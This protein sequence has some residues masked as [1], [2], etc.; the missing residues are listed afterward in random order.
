MSEINDIKITIHTGK[1]DID[2]TL[3]ASKAPLT[4][5]NFLNLASK[6][7]Y[8][9]VAFHRIIENF[10]VQGGDPDGTGRGGPGY[11]FADEFHP[12]LRHDRPGILSMANAG[13]G[14]NGS[15]FFIT[16]TPTPF[17]DNRHSVFGV[18]TGG[19]DV[20]NSLVGKNNTGEPGCK[21]DPAGKG[22]AITSITIHD[23]TDALFEARK[24]DIESWNAAIG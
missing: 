7:Y 10:M 3:F 5:A 4:C 1:G 6:G 23:S 21:A 11:R 19:L 16:T 15:Q 13:P 22:D 14:T 17:L 9:G 2:V 18:V 8:D 24:D 20:V 12:E